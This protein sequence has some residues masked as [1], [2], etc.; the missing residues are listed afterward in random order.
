MTIDEMKAILAG[1]TD[2]V[3]R[4]FWERQIAYEEAMLA[5]PPPKC[6]TCGDFI[7][8]DGFC[9]TCLLRDWRAGKL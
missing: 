4:A 2:D 9:T 5:N 8:P 1:T 7:A 6:P 3:R